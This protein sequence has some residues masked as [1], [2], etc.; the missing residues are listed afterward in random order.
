MRI[1]N[2]KESYLIE[3]AIH[4]NLPGGLKPQGTQRVGNCPFHDDHHASLKV[5]PAKQIY[6]CFACGAQGDIISFFT[7]QGKTYAEAKNI[8]TNGLSDVKDLP[9]RTPKSA[10]EPEWIDAIPDTVIDTSTIQHYK[11]GAPS[12]VWAYHNQYGIVTGYTC[13]F[14]LPEGKKDVLPYTYKTNGSA[15][16]WMWKGFDILRPL[17][18]LHELTNRPK[19][20]VLVVEGEKT[21]DAA[22][23]L[24]PKYVVTTWIGGAASV[25]NTDWS[26][27]YGR[28]IYLWNDN[29]LAGLLCMFGGWQKN[30]ND[31]TYKR[32]TGICEMFEAEFK[33]IQNSKE[34]PKKW[35]VADADWSPAEAQ[36]Y[37]KNNRV[38]IPII[39]AYPPNEIPM[40][41]PLIPVAPPLPEIIPEKP[42]FLDSDAPEE[43][44]EHFKALGFENND[45]NLFVFFVFRT[46]VIIKLSAGGIGVSNLLQLAPLNYW[47]GRYPKKS[48][49]KFDVTSVADH[50]IGLCM[51][52]GIF[53]PD[54]IRGR[55]AWIDNNVP[56][57]HCGDILIVD[58]KYTDFSKHKSKF[59]YE[60]GRELGFS[61][62]KPATKIQANKLVAMLERLNWGRPVNAQ[63]LAGWIVIAPLCGALKWRSHMWLTGSSG[64]GKSE[65][66]K[67]FIK[68]FLG[69]IFVDAQGA[70]TEAGIRQYLKADA[71]PVVFDEAESEDKKG[72]ERM[73]AVLE[74]MRASSTSDSGKII[75]GSSGGNASQFNIRS[76][77]AFASI[78][79]NLTQRSDIS[80]ITVLEIKTD[81]REDKKQRWAET[82]DIYQE[83]VTEDFVQ[84]FQSRSIKLLPTILKNATTFSNA[85]AAELDNQRAGDQ[86]GTL[87]AGAYSLY[88][89][90]IISYEDAK[91]WIKERDWSEER[92]ID[93]TRDE[94]KILAKIMNAEITV[95]THV[96]NKTR[97]IGELVMVGIAKDIKHDYESSLITKELAENT[98]RRVGIRV[99][100][101]K[102]V[103]SDTSDFIN[104]ALTSI[105]FSGKYAQYLTR[106]D[107]A[108]KLEAT[109]F[110]A[111]VKSRATRIE[112][113]VIFGD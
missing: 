26:P 77:F 92:L 62:T 29:D 63:L 99:E 86:L 53:N 110:A 15:S 24:F 3:E 9:V 51:K 80:R 55:G 42:V 17:Y 7:N 65:I 1:E 40:E 85:A 44:N 21:A 4:N 70:T 90:S 43:K 22:R 83:T 18:N 81:I 79:A 5:S 28:K 87:L 96:G 16:K 2:I 75:K 25:K 20:I 113:S 108:E 61:I 101:Q 102:V 45:Q 48:T 38:E 46:N 89:D 47:E 71:L 95:E 88:S 31:D 100:G 84:A 23:V 27:L 10:P 54:K 68:K 35:D 60:A 97:T 32:V 59:I 52:Q 34:F 6:K 91:K 14:D 11:Y 50:L 39:S 56:V 78:G 105:G 107:N 74:I 112:S 49:V 66:M 41:L 103:F 57:I 37:V 93:G 33:R 30:E 111:G 36:E 106:I 13:R 109:T 67:L 72:A 76:C 8:I 12:G 94:M 82:L 69:D 58:G 104:K 64:S 19:A 98:L 73:Q